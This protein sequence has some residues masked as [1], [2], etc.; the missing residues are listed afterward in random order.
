[1]RWRA[2]GRPRKSWMSC[3]DCWTSTRGEADEQLRELDY[4]GTSADS[5]LDVVAF[6]L[7]RRG[8]CGSVCRGL[9]GL[10]ERV[11]ALRAGGGRACFDDGVAGRHFLVVACASESGRADWGGRSF[12]V[13]GNVHPKRE[14]AVRLSRPSRRVS[15]RTTYWDVVVGGSVVSG[16]PSAESE[17]RWRVAPDRKNAP[18]GDQAIGRG[19]VRKMP[20]VAAG[21]GSRS[22]YPVL[23]VPPAGRSGGAGMVTSRGAA[24][25]EGADQLD[26][27]ANRSG[28]CA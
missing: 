24:A 5:R 11:G 7:A 18:Q 13:G 17:N 6:P 9:R 26:G 3:A 8:A 12:D 10:P 15:S 16:R 23:R 14:R 28:H 25:G 4:A 22:R 20:G 2:G 27:G 21:N 19:A 1:M